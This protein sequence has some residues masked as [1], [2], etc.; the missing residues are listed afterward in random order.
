MKR[1]ILKKEGI[2]N[3]DV[4]DLSRTHPNLIEHEM[5]WPE[6]NDI[7]PSNKKLFFDK[8]LLNNPKANHSAFIAYINRGLGRCNSDIHTSE[9]SQEEKEYISW[10]FATHMCKEQIAKGFPVLE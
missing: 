1:F 2:A 6:I 8:N 4:V 10:L 3:L 9:Y 7:Y 5:F